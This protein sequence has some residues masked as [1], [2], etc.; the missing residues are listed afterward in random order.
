MGG[1][2]V[3]PG[4]IG[5]EGSVREY[6][7]GRRDHRPGH[8]GSSDRLLPS[9]QTSPV[10]ST[11]DRGSSRLRFSRLSTPFVSPVPSSLRMEGNS[12]GIEE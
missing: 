11:L 9:A 5:P 3:G 10:S 2:L 7:L 12:S 8:K 1:D 6:P 4:V